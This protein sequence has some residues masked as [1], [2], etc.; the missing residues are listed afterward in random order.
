M[1][2]LLC[3]GFPTHTTLSSKN[4]EVLK[5]PKFQQGLR[6]VKEREETLLA[7]RA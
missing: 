4:L 2:L 5:V 1:L 6:K 3:Q 7:M